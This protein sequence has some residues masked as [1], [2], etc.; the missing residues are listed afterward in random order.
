MTDKGAINVATIDRFKDSVDTGTI[1]DA[2]DLEVPLSA[3]MKYDYLAAIHT[4][5]QLDKLAR[6]IENRKRSRANLKDELY[7][8]CKQAL[9]KLAEDN[10]ALT[11]KK[12]DD[13][14]KTLKDC[15]REIMKIDSAAKESDK[16]AKIIKDGVSAGS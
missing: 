9:K 7:K 5:E 3:Q 8:S 14:I 15:R 6:E 1:I 11:L 12:I 13:A 10:N 4:M 16:L 2:N